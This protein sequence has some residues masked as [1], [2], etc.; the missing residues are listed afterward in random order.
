MQFCITADPGHCQDNGVEN[1]LHNVKSDRVYCGQDLKRKLNF[2]RNSG[3]LQEIG[4]FPILAYLY[5]QFFNFLKKLVPIRYLFTLYNLKLAR[6]MCFLYYNYNFTMQ[7]INTTHD[8][9]EHVLVVITM[10]REQ[11]SA[12]VITFHYPFVTNSGF[13]DI[14]DIILH[15]CP[16]FKLCRYLPAVY[17]NRCF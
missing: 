9:R 13:I 16:S 15:N 6:E 7:C 2:F 1:N 14:P 5:I 4:K 10:N 8:A 3:T 17:V 11:F 12:T